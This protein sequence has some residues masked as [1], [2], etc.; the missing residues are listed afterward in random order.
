MRQYLDFMIKLHD[1]K[2][3]IILRQLPVSAAHY[4][5]L[6]LNSWLPLLKWLNPLPCRILRKLKEYSEIAGGLKH[7][8]SVIPIDRIYSI[9]N[10][11]FK[12]PVVYDFTLA[13]Y[14]G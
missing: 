14:A 9:E 1:I 3:T 11:M 2:Q 12:I 5:L 7:P 13:R 6:R 8:V 4:G 10:L